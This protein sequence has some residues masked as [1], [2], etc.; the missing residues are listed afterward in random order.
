MAAFARVFAEVDVLA[1][2]TVSYPR[3]AGGP[4]VRDSGRRC[5]GPL[6]ESVQPLRQPRDLASVR[7]AE[8]ELPAGLQLAAAVGEDELLLP[9]Q[10]YT[11]G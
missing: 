3:S 6:H 8:G 4:A 11:R 5:R 7:L 2:P 9:S 10:A 1:G